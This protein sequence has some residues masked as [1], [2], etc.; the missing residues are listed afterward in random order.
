MQER[1]R[2]RSE[3]PGEAARLYLQSAAERHGLM[4]LTLASEDGLMM[5]AAS[6]AE[7]PL[8]L[9]WIAAL[10][11]VAALPGRRGRPLG[12]LIERETDGQML[13][14]AEIVLRGEKLYLTAVGGPLPPLGE[15]R[16]AV[17]RILARSLPA[18]A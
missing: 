14:S 11:C 8:N 18:M 10:G 9:D 12:A 7:R 2:Q 4:A 1:R 16:A 3:A 17:E 5:A 13:T 15:T 6:R